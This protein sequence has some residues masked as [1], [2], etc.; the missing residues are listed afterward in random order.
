MELLVSLGVRAWRLFTIA[1]IG[2]AAAAA[3]MR[4]TAE[5]VRRLMEC[6]VA[7]RTDT[8]ITVQFSCE[9]YTGPYEGEVR[10]AYFFCHAGINIASVLIDGS[11]SA[12]PNIDRH[13]VQGN[14]YRDDFLEVWENCF[15]VMRDRRW[16]RTG[17][18]KTCGAYKNCNGG[19]MHLWDENQD[20]VL[21]CLYRDIVI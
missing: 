2:R 20:A 1:P 14:I 16:T 4:L 19:A 3:D 12:C 15:A 7:A 21:A 18:C 11:I 8:R 10:D 6:I 13:F 17:P 5:E 9:A